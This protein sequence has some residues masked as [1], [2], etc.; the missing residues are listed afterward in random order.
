[1]PRAEEQAGQDKPCR[2]RQGGGTHSGRLAGVDVAIVDV[3][4]LRVDG[5]VDGIVVR[6]PGV[7]VSVEFLQSS[8]ERAR[9]LTIT[10]TL[11]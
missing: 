10:T 4:W 1:M 9:E 2:H 7:V 6:T 3:S 8:R 5:G 11:M